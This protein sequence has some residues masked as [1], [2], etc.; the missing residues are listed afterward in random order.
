MCKKVRDNN[1]KKRLSSFTFFSLH[2]TEFAEELSEGKKYSGL[3]G[4]HLGWYFL[5]FAR[6]KSNERETLLRW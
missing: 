1:L 3:A 5:F 2:S 4:W 6:K